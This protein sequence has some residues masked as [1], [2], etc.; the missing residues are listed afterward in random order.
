MKKMFSV[1]LT[2]LMLLSVLPFSVFAEGEVRSVHS[3][4]EMTAYVRGELTARSETVRFRYEGS[5]Y[6][7]P[8]LDDLCAYGGDAHAGDYLRLSF[9]TMP[10]TVEENG[11]YTVSASFY[12]DAGQ[13]A[14]VDAYVEDALAACPDGTDYEKAEYI[15]DYLCENVLFDLENLNNEQDLLK[16]TAYGAAVNGRAVCQGFAALYYRLALAAGL[17]CRVVTG[18]RSDVKHA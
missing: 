2:A 15:Y 7:E 4:E 6:R 8:T 3:Y 18:T 11:V 12:T 17:D 10:K 1:I 13:E 9:R 16:Y 5:D 14:A